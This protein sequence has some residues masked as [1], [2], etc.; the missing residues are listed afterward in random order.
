MQSVI[1]FCTWMYTKVNA[2]NTGIDKQVTCLGTTQRAVMNS[3]F[4]LKLEKSTNPKSRHIAMDNH[5]QCPELAVILREKAHIYST[6]T[7]RANRKDGIK[8]L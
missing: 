4:A 3:V 8:R 7:V 5:Y 1:A 2:S 6:G